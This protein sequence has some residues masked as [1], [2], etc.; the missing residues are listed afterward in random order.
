LTISQAAEQAAFFCFLNN[1]RRRE[2]MVTVYFP[3]DSHGHLV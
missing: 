1:R 3:I 2:R